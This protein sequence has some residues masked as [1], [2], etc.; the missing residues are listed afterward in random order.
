MTVVLSECRAGN[1]RERIGQAVSFRTGG[2]EPHG[3]PNALAV[4]TRLM[5]ELNRAG[6]HS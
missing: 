3:S 6:V 4:A 1:Q 5:G 2:G